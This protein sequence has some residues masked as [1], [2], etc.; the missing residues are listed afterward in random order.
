MSRC[1]VAQRG[2]IAGTVQAGYNHADPQL[3]LNPH[4]LE[5]LLYH[6]RSGGSPNY[7]VLRSRLLRSRQSWTDFQSSEIVLVSDK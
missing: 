1:R 5:L 7:V 4:T 3:L 2:R 6:R